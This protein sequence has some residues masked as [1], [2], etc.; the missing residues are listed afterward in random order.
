[1]SAPLIFWKAGDRI[2]LTRDDS[3]DGE[4]HFIPKN[5][6]EYVDTTVHLD[7]PADEAIGAM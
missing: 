3:N 2:K 4:H 5:W 1:M 7:R 6:V